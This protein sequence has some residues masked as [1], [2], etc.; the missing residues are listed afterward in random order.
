MGPR[1]HLIDAHVYI[2]R[3]YHA[4]PEMQAPDGTP[5]HAAYGF[6]NTLLRI[7]AELEP[8]HLACCFD[9]SLVSFRN[10]LELDYKA[11]RTE[12]PADLEPQFE[13]CLRASRALGIASFSVPD[14]EADDV[15]GTLCTGLLAHS[16]SVVVMSSDKDL[17]QLVTEDGRVV[18]LDF[19]RGRTLDAAGVREKFGVPP[20][21]IPDY[22]G[23]VGDAVDNLPGVPGIGPRSA[24]AIL[25]CFGALDDVPPPEDAKA[26][27]EVGIRGAA[28]LAAALAE[29][30]ERALRTRDLATVR[31]DVPDLD[32]DPEA[33]RYRGADRGQVKRLFSRLGW[34]EIAT[35]IRRFADDPNGG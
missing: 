11:G 10:R 34:G 9:H 14:F 26:W 35:R 33:L 20:A 25:E 17:A 18:H 7:L 1:V 24:A 12:A 27:A 4:L 3:A 22:L 32:S 16:A 19:A 23:L 21:R 5:T 28:R 13:L 6:T 30:R 2:F 29:H 15:I 31:R 8:T